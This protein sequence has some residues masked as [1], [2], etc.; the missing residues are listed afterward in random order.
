MMRVMAASSP[1][2]ALLAIATTSVT[3]RA[4]APA[5]PAKVDASATTTM[6]PSAWMVR[7]NIAR[8]VG[9]SSTSTTRIALAPTPTLT[10]SLPG[11]SAPAPSAPGS[12]ALARSPALAGAHADLPRRSSTMPS[13]ARS[14]NADFTM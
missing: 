10:P 8:W 2:S 1:P 5:A 6:S 12:L 13:R 9:D 7:R 3:E 11:G 4:T 14:S